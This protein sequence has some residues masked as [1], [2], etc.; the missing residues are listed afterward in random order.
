MIYHNHGLAM[1]SSKSALHQV[2]IHHSPW[3]W[4]ISNSDLGNKKIYILNDYQIIP[5]GNE[6]VNFPP[7]PEFVKISWTSFHAFGNIKE[8]R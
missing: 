7:V 2:S 8:S 4:M 6:S 1:E 3:T 5:D